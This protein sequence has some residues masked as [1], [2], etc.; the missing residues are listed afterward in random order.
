MLDLVQAMFDLDGAAKPACAGKPL[1][2]G[3]VT[4]TLDPRYLG[5]GDGIVWP[6]LTEGQDGQVELHL[7]NATGLPWLIRSRPAAKVTDPGTV[8]VN[9]AVLMAFYHQY[10]DGGPFSQSMVLPAVTKT[11]T[12]DGDALPGLVELRL[13]GFA[14]QAMALIWAVRFV[15]DLFFKG[16]EVTEALAKPDFLGCVSDLV[17]SQTA[18]VTGTGLGAFIKGFF[19][20]KDPIVKALGGGEKRLRPVDILFAALAGGATLVLNDL[21]SMYRTVAGTDDTKVVVGRT[22]GRL[23]LTGGGVGPLRFGSS[24]SAAETALK[25]A[26]GPPDRVSDGAFCDL[27]G[28]DP[29]RL[30]VLTWGNLSVSL[31][32]P[33]QHGG[34]LEL[35]SWKVSGGRPAAPVTMPHGLAPGDTYRDL[36]TKAPGAHEEAWISGDETQ[37]VDPGGVQYF[38]EQSSP[39]GG[40]PISLIAAALVPCE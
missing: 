11:Y 31:E 25:A 8:D 37:L 2:A 27:G 40:T 3:D 17:K 29:G 23:A 33:H 5:K 19:D 39:S 15:L 20:C 34:G 14:Q 36:I 6:C 1:K 22:A 32:G 24:G 4:Y 30:R 13:D 12:F 9:K 28:G 35:R 38:F 26:F 7:A 16:A 18:G 21:V 10:L